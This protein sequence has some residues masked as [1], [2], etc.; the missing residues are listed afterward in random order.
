MGREAHKKHGG[1][2]QRFGEEPLGG[3]KI[4]LFGCGLKCF[5][6]L[7]GTHSKHNV[8]YFF[9]L[10]INTLKKTVKAPAVDLLRQNTPR[11][12]MQKLSFNP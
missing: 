4:L 3:T 9:L 2:H 1:A 5:L 11:G 6:P 7:R 12:T 8:C 10:I